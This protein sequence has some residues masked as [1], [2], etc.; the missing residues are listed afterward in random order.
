M[1]SSLAIAGAVLGAVTILYAVMSA[2]TDE[3]K[4]QGVLNRLEAAV[5]VAPGGSTGPIPDVAAVVRVNDAE[6]WLIQSVRG[7]RYLELKLNT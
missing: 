5:Q 3:E 4:L 1:K 7:F 6:V 2:E